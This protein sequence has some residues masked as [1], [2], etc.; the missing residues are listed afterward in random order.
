MKANRFVTIIV[1]LA[2]LCAM[3]INYTGCAGKVQPEPSE[4]ESPTESATS[5]NVGYYYHYEAGYSKAWGFA[6][7]FFKQ[8]F[9][10]RKNTLVAPMSALVS[11]AM[12]CNGAEGETKAQMEEALGIRAD[13]LNDFLLLFYSITF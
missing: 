5:Y 4:S 13:R 3:L 7:E 8:N 12:V 9:S 6:V 10:F 2:L 11:L 1:S